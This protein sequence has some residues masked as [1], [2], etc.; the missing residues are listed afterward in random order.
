MM[1]TARLFGLAKRKWIGKKVLSKAGT[2]QIGH[3]FLQPPTLSLSRTFLAIVKPYSV[4]TEPSQQRV[5]V[6]CCNSL[7]TEDT[8]ANY[9]KV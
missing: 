9:L 4:E 7:T 1:F 5:R 2:V 3:I 6:S 8:R